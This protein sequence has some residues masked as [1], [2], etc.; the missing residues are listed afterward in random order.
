M[1]NVVFNLGHFIRYKYNI[2][3]AFLFALMYDIDV[4]SFVFLMKCIVFNIVVGAIIMKAVRGKT[5]RENRLNNKKVNYNV[6][7]S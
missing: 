7:F 2:V 5:I 4:Y 1:F 3:F 6:R